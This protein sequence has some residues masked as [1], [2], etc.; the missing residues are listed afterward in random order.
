MSANAVYTQ[1]QQ[2]A[3]GS[4]HAEKIL[5]GKRDQLETTG[6]TPQRVVVL[7]EP[8]EIVGPLEGHPACHRRLELT[9]ELLTHV[10]ESRAP[11]RQQ[12]LLGSAGEKVHGRFSNVD[13]NLPHSLNPIHHQVGTG[14]PGRSREPSQVYRI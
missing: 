14:F 9:N 8:A 3:Q 5:I 2:H 4:V 11:W 12:P 6:I 7:S 1:V 13:R 10:D